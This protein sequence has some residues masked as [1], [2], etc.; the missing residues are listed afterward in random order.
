[1]HNCIQTEDLKPGMVIVQVTKQ[2]GPLKIRKSGLVTS[3]EMVQGLL[4]MGIQEVQIDPNQTVEIEIPVVQSSTTMQLLQS[5]SSTQAK[6]D[7]QLHDQFNRRL[8]LPSVQD[9]PSQWQLYVK[10]GVTMLVLALAGLILGFGIAYLP[11][12]LSLRSPLVVAESAN[13]AAD[14]T[15]TQ[16]P[17]TVDTTTTV[18]AQSSPAIN[19]PPVL[20]Q[21]ITDN[22]TSE[23]IN[24]ID[25]DVTNPPKQAKDIQVADVPLETKAEVLQQNKP[26]KP[27]PVSPELLKRFEKVI[28]Q[29]N[30]EEH[31]ASKSTKAEQMQHNT[32]NSGPIVDLS[33]FPLLDEQNEILS[34]HRKAPAQTIRD[35][36]VQD[37]PRIDQLPDW[38]MGELPSMAFSAHMY[39]SLPSERWVRVNGQ[40]RREGDLIDDKV[41]IVKIAAQ[42]V[43]LNY[44]GHEFSV[45]AMTDW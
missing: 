24:Q 5:N 23:S 30:R 42:H 34:G 27:E 12:V 9:I 26:I 19:P 6:A 20:T 39:A 21:S 11:S 8:F 35:K 17:D 16:L 4:E 44:A 7:H 37:V 18:V 10:R 36:N 29:M 45:Q 41:R 33:E 3:V 13:T 14:K 43:I 2:N 15:L 25:A 22:S 1:M 38:V 28:Q 31:Y 40:N 32:D